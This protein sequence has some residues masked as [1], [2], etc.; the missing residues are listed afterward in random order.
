MHLPTSLHLSILRLL[1]YCPR[2]S[3]YSTEP[4]ALAL[5]QA[6]S[7]TVRPGL[8]EVEAGA[9]V[10]Q[11]QAPVQVP[12]SSA[13]AGMVDSPATARSPLSVRFCCGPPLVGGRAC[14]SRVPKLEVRS[15]PFLLESLPFRLESYLGSLQRS[16]EILGVPGPGS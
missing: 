13:G 11:A 3:T 7:L 5:P 14:R 2:V 16:S 15:L 12:P 6:A 1:P 4:Q 10:T 9:P 8:R